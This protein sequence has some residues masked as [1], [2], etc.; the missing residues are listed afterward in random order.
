MVNIRGCITAL[1]TPFNSLGKVDEKNLK[2]LIKRQIDNGVHGLVP[3]GTTGESPTLSHKE[4]IKVIEITVKEVKRRIPV[5]AGTG[6]NSTQ[7]A[8]ELTKKAESL[9]ADASLQV[10]PYYNKPTQRGLYNHFNSIASNTKLPII[11]Y[12]IPGRSVISLDSKTIQELEKKNKNIIGI[13][14]ASGDLKKI[15]EIKKKCTEKF[16]ILSGEDNLNL[17]ILKN[18]GSGFISV[19]SNLYPHYCSQMY[20]FYMS[21]NIKKSN[22]INSYLKKINKLL[23]VETNPIPIKYALAKYNLIKNELRLPLTQLDPKYYKKI[24]EELKRLKKIQKI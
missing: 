3:C 12:N 9:G 11:L 6:S 18:G 17:D 4:H 7:E 10:V 5:I 13:K 16:L 15:I 14:E 2:K 21:N 8:I 22:Q 19:T 24:N 23:F 1:V 20:N